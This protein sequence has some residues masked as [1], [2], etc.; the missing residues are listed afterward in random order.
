MYIVEDDCSKWL[1]ELQSHLC[2]ESPV[3]VLDAYS[4]AVLLIAAEL[5]LVVQLNYPL[6]L[7]SL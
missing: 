6:L 5:G 4:A 2:N 7:V 3:G 1:I